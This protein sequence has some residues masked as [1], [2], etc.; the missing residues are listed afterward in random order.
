MSLDGALVSHVPVALSKQKVTGTR[1]LTRPSDGGNFCL[2]N[3]GLTLQIN[4][5]YRLSQ[6]THI[7][8]SHEPPLGTANPIK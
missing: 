5:V 6:E 1:K 4:T 7:P 2:R 3:V 8:S